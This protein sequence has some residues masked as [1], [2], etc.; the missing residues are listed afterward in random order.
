MSVRVM[1]RCK[2]CGELWPDD[3]LNKHA[4]CCFDNFQMSPEDIRDCYE[5]SHFY[6]RPGEGNTRPTKEG[7]SQG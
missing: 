1:F 2:K 6:R 3:D 7:T 5:F 4:A